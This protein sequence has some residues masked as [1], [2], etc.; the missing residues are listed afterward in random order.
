MR[1]GTAHVAGSSPHRG[2]ST[3]HGRAI[4]RS[5]SVVNLQRV[6]DPTT[7]LRAADGEPLSLLTV[8]AHPDDE[9][10]KGAPTLALYGRAGVRTTLV[11]CTGGE[12]GDLQNPT[13]REPGQP[14]HRID[15]D[16]RVC[17]GLAMRARPAAS[18]TTSAS[19]NI[20]FAFDALG[21][22]CDQAAPRDI[23]RRGGGVSRE[24]LDPHA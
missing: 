1:S 4:G 23:P 9:A 10:S 20:R 2:R 6:A 13:L 21:P 12:E 8:H 14:F 3:C 17:F 7:S 15:D 19:A 11:C 16:E 18:M 24:A 22:G 5:G